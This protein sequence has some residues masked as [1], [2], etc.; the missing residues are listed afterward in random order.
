M[1]PVSA[2]LLLALATGAAGAAGGQ[3]WQSL[4]T[5]VRRWRGHAGPETAA[6]GELEPVPAQAELTALEGEP[7]NEHRARLL[8]AALA[9]RAGMD[10][11]FAAALDAWHQ[12][13]QQAVASTGAGNVSTHI[14]GGNQ[15]TVVTTRDV[16]G[17]L[18]FGTPAS[19]PP[20]PGQ[21]DGP[22]TSGD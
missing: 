19:P 5:L 22:G 20:P 11:G 7:A 18:H 15:G 17:G 16:A 6:S 3:S 4:V 13:A 2:A 10:A 21:S 12:E 14:S 1:E 9:A 8:S